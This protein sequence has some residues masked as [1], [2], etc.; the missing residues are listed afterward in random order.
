MPFSYDI[1]DIKTGLKVN[2]FILKLCRLDMARQQSTFLKYLKEFLLLGRGD[3]RVDFTHLMSNE[4]HLI[5][6]M[7]LGLIRFISN[8]MKSITTKLV[9]NGINLLCILSFYFKLPKDLALYTLQKFYD[10]NYTIIK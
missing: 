10:L 7:F 8:Y 9:N 4:S 2:F 6:E 3:K 5:G 1:N